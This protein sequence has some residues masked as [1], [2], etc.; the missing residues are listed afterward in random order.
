MAPG[1]LLAALACAA[2]GV[3]F[4]RAA[5]VVTE[6]S[7][8]VAGP[9]D[10]MIPCAREPRAWRER[11]CGSGRLGA[12]L[13]AL[14]ARCCSRASSFSIANFGVTPYGQTLRCGGGAAHARSSR[15]GSRAPAPTP[16]APPQRP[17]ASWCTAA[18]AP[19]TA[20]R[21][22][23]YRRAAAFWGRRSSW[24]EAG[25]RPRPPH[26]PPPSPPPLPI[27]APVRVRHAASRHRR[28]RP[29]R[30]GGLARPPRLSFASGRG[31]DPS[32]AALAPP[33]Q[34]PPAR[35]RAAS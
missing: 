30:C 25:D 5:F 18:R 17:A 26:A 8:L 14:T 21:A 34:R 29:G 20:T 19:P 24:R 11:G 32:R 2:V 9:P 15:L 10:S 33:P 13:T 22:R 35:P 1:R 28:H 12:A 3:G 4:A 23:R 31:A 6:G 27:P 7:M 16:P